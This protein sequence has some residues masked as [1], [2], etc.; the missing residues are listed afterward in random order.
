MKRIEW[1]VCRD[2]QGTKYLY[3]VD[4]YGAYDGDET[5]DEWDCGYA[6]RGDESWDVFE[7]DSLGNGNFIAS[8]QT[9]EDA[10]LIAQRH[11]DRRA[12]V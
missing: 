12:Q 10:K 8:A 2:A 9:M 7:D 1:K 6:I 11:A 4:P 3:G 5:G